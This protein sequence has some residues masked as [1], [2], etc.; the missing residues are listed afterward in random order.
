M[1][2][3]TQVF[4]GE[5]RLTLFPIGLFSEVDGTQVSFE[6]DYVGYKQEHLVHCFPVRIVS[7]FENRTFYYIGFQG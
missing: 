2:P 1:L 6:E 7:V 4:H 3:A 5:D